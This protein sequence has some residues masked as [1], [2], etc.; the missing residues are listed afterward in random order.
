M[1]AALLRGGFRLFNSKIILT[2]ATALSIAPRLTASNSCFSTNQQLCSDEV[3]KSKT[4]ATT[5]K[6]AD[7]IFGKILRKEI[8]ADII[9]EDD[10]VQCILV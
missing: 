3:D 7:T 5:N 8:P 9:Y 6:N 2:A 1:A 10:K 4:A